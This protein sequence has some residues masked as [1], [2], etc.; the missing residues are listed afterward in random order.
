MKWKQKM[1]TLL[2]D[3]GYYLA[4]AVC[5]TA[6]AVSGWLFVRSLHTPD[7]DL[8]PSDAVQAAV[9]PTM[10]H[11]QSANRPVAEAPVQSVKPNHPVAPTAPES[12]TTQENSGEPTGETGPSVQPGAVLC[13]PL[14][15]TV[16]QS[17]S[18]D[19]LAYNATTRDWRTHDGMDIAASEGSEVRA[20]AEGT[21]LSVFA[22]D[23]FGQT[24]TVE[25]A[26]GYVTHYSNLA[27]EVAVSAGDRV[28]AGQTLGT[29]GKTALAE[30]GSEPHLHFAVYKN[31]VPQDPQAYLGN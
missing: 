26:G 28:S 21:V 16:V 24:V 4:F 13:R 10:P 27:E 29:V 6:V 8:A 11:A 18:M 3:K 23:L 7:D 25:H 12:E 1:K 22:D 14:E 31:N 19:K 15:G 2:R 20:V 5:L 9:L 30:V 17:Y